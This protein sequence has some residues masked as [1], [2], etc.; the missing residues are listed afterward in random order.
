MRYPEIMAAIIHFDAQLDAV[1][2]EI[3]HI[4]TRRVL[5]T[6]AKARPLPT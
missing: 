1:A 6:E 3:Q 4:R 5:A 2:I